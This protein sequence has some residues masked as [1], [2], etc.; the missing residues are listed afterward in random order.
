MI[1]KSSIRP[2]DVLSWNGLGLESDREKGGLYRQQAFEL[3]GMS[4]GVE[5]GVITWTV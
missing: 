3:S 1:Y 4:S 2:A 5:S